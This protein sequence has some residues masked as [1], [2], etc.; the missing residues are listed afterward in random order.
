MNDKVVTF[1]KYIKV[2]IVCAY[3]YKLNMVVIGDNLYKSR[4]FLGNA[5]NDLNVKCY[6]SQKDQNVLSAYFLIIAAAVRC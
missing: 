5:S 2:H 4:T 6:T 1:S 3:L